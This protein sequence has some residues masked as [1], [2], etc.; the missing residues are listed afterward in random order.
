MLI[1][2]GKQARQAARILGRAETQPKNAALTCL[3]EQL[4]AQSD[5]ILAANA[6]DVAESQE[7]GLSPALLDDFLT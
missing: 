1:E 2:M 3:A 7:A 4:L 5:P 6:Q